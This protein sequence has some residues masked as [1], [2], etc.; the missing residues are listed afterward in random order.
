MYVFRYFYEFVII[1]IINLINIF[2]PLCI[3]I[4]I[5]VVPTILRMLQRVLG[6]EAFLN[7]IEIFV[8]KEHIE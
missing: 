3:I 4:P 2:N 1:A 8:R 7:I 6:D 5:I